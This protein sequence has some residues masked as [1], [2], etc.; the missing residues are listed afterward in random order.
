MSCLTHISSKANL[1]NMSV[2]CLQTQTFQID[3]VGRKMSRIM[4][5]ADFR[6][7][8]NKDAD[9]LHTD[10]CLCLR[11]MD[12]T[13]PLLSKSEFLTSSHLLWLYSP[14]CF[15]HGRKPQRPVF[16]Q[17]GSNYFVLLTV[18]EKTLFSNEIVRKL[19]KCR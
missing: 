12:S 7:C 16:S 4:R 17:Q 3:L 19:N 2:C 14:V 9:Q 15:G 13:I 18:P 8:Q 10:Q 5:K 1:E 6:I 11:Y